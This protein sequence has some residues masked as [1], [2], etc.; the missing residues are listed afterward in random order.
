MIKKYNKLVRDKI[1]EIIKKA[2]ENPSIRVLSDEEFPEAV[3]KK[4]LE[5]AKELIEAKDR[6]EVINEIVDILELLDVLITEIG[7]SGLEICILRRKKNKKRGAFKKRIYLIKT[8][9][10]PRM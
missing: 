8:E 4:L 5:E 3:K 1:P 10:K 7:I 2:G 9:T 6:K